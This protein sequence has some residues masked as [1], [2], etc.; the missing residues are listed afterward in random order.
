[1]IPIFTATLLED[2]R[3]TG[4]HDIVAYLHTHMVDFFDNWTSR[5]IVL[6]NS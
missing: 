6:A 3:T 5:E 2:E 4:H 1:M